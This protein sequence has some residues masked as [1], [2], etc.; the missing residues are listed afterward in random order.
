[1]K[2]LPREDL[3]AI[4]DSVDWEPL[5]GARTLLTGG[6]GWVG[7]WLVESF[8]A[9][10]EQHQLG[11]TLFVLA[12]RRVDYPDPAVTMIEGDVINLPFMGMDFTHVIHA[13]CPANARMEEDDPLG[14][15][16]TIVDG[17]REVLYFNQ[18]CKRFLYISSGAALKRPNTVY[19]LA[20]LAAEMQ[21]R[22]H[23]KNGMNI[24]IARPYALIGPGL[25]L[26]RHFAM[27]NFIRMALEGGPVKVE[28]GLLVYRS[29]LYASDLATRLW[30]L[31]L[32]GPICEPVDVG[33]DERLSI[34]DLACL[35][36]RLLKV[37]VE[38]TNKAQPYDNYLPEN[39]AHV[40]VHLEEAILK[41]ARWYE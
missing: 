32:S 29:Y 21:C 41:T 18:H 24:A 7:S 28:G 15:W 1:M 2:L 23:A 14:L 11:A 3:K 37:E 30:N 17:T 10:N 33:S 31:L 40:S 6:T 34:Y 5:R 19:G 12:R 4:V 25:P 8:S 22:I 38:V 26:D 20:K 35:V 27:G 9:A 16:D 39:P 36:A 13:A